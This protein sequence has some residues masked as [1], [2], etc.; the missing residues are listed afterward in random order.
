MTRRVFFELATTGVCLIA[1]SMVLLRS[2]LLVFYRKVKGRLI[3]NQFPRAVLQHVAELLPDGERVSVELALNSR[4][5]SDYDGASEVF[6]WGMFDTAARLSADQ[7]H[8]IV[9]LA[10]SSLLSQAGNGI[11]VE[12]DF[13]TFCV[14]VAD[15]D[16]QWEVSMIESGM[17]QQAVC[18]ACAALGVGLMFHAQGPDGTKLSPRQSF[19]VKI[20]LGAMKP[21]YQ[22]SFWSR[23]APGSERPWLP[24]NLPDPARD[25]QI[26]L[27]KA[28]EKVQCDS[29]AGTAVTAGNLSQ[30]LWAARG[31]TPHLYKSKPWG[32]TIPTWQG[33]QN[34][35][36]ILVAAGGNIYK[37][38]NWK[39][40]RPTHR[41][42]C[43]AEV[44]ALLRQLRDAFPP[45]KSFIVLS[46][47]EPHARA[48]WE[49]GYQLLN[50]VVQASALGIA[51]RTIVLRDQDRAAFAA[52]DPGKPVVMIGLK[53][54]D[55]SFLA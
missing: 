2:E 15:L 16:G 9:N 53:G 42:E 28:L 45:W 8:R 54:L 6:H 36:G 26:P 17:Q 41:L 3:T 13:L 51:Y 43:V 24:G 40:A 22:G 47:N 12:N 30:L 37:Y 21:S 34:L 23:S 35:T 44:P 32:L 27:V 14:D 48:L 4:C 52:I 39:N 33:L 20:Q 19:T 7:I 49:I 50:I 11:N 46:V 5:S 10:G 55:S 31:R 38:V 29:G 18:L 25:G 1:G